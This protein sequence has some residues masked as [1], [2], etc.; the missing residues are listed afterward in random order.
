MLDGTLGF[1]RDELFMLGADR[2]QLPNM[3][4]PNIALPYLAEN[5]EI[6]DL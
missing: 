5:R 1:C 4:V 3:A 6:I 2:V